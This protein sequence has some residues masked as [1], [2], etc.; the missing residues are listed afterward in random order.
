MNALER[1][2]VSPRPDRPSPPP[3]ALISRLEERAD[4]LAARVAELERLLA[5]R[6]SPPQTSPSQPRPPQP[7]LGPRLRTTARPRPEATADEYWL[8]R[9]EGFVVDSPSGEVGVV[10]GVRFQS[11]HDRPD[12][13]EVRVGKLRPEVIVVP[14]AEVDD[15][16]AETE[17]IVLRHDPRHPRRHRLTSRLRH[18]RAL[19][20]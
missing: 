9:C 16:S 2:L 5:A 6:V 17:Q 11:R 3:E 18:L 12:E 8:R 4:E 20:Q 14:V 15:I 19:Q 1:Q 10:E 13:L 7:S